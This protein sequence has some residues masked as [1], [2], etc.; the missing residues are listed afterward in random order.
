MRPK[1]GPPGGA[2]QR[3]KTIH[4]SEVDASA[5]V[6]MYGQRTGL[7]R[8]DSQT[9]STGLGRAVGKRGSSNTLYSGAPSG[10]EWGDCLH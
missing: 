8:S 7:K 5:A 4:L 3:P 2:R 9:S 1:S 10:M 6:N